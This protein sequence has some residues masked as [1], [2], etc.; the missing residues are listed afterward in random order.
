MPDDVG[1]LR[2]R[3]LQQC[4]GVIIGGKLGEFVPPYTH[5]R[6]R[7][8]HQQPLDQAL[9]AKLAHDGN[10]RDGFARTHLHE[11]G[12]ASASFQMPERKGCGILLVLVGR[13]ADG[14]AILLCN[15]PVVH[16]FRRPYR[17]LHIQ[18][19]GK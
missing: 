13:S 2:S 11:Q 8:Y 14:K 7:A 12:C 1:P 10:A 15:H 3:T 16:P 9:I 4:E 18:A 17:A 6:N 5:D 19:T